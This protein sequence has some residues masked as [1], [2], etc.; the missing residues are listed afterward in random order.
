LEEE[1]DRDLD[2]DN[3]IG[4]LAIAEYQ[5][6]KLQRV[7]DGRLDRSNPVVFSKGSSTYI[8][9]TGDREYRIAIDIQTFD[10]RD[11]SITHSIRHAIQSPAFIIT[12][13]L[14]TAIIC[15]LA[16][17]SPYWTSPIMGSLSDSELETLDSQYSLILDRCAIL[18]NGDRPNPRSPAALYSTCSKAV[19]QLDQI[20][21]EYPMTVC[22][23]ERIE[24]YLTG[25]KPRL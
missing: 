7:L 12:S 13:T 11:K 24:L 8:F 14:C 6:N 23:D 3:T 25:N 22:D 10:T 18:L 20:C 15:L 17:A 21:E 1:R 9:K 4:R 16:F 5:V 2:L 19:V